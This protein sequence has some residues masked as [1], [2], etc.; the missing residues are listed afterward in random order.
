MSGAGLWL[1]ATSCAS[2]VRTPPRG[3]HPPN[4]AEPVVVEYPPPPARA[5][6]V[7]ADPGEA[8]SWIDGHFSWV[9]RRWQWQPGGW[10]RAPSDCYYAPPILVWLPSE[11]H[12][13]LY[14][15]RPRWYPK[16]YES[17]SQKDVLSAC[18]RVVTCGKPAE[19][20]RSPGR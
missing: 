6:M 10:Q 12:G 8:C 20:Y 17:R 13:E 9:G 5:E 3:P 2:F 11:G 7:T 19:P 16:D 4:G 14:Y 18:S 1:V 15:M